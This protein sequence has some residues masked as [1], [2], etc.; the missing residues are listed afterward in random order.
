[1]DRSLP[2]RDEM[3][4]DRR[5]KYRTERNRRDYDVQRR[6]DGFPVPNYRRSFKTAE[7]DGYQNKRISRDSSSSDVKMGGR[8]DQRTPIKRRNPEQLIRAPKKARVIPRK[9]AT[10]DEGETNS[11]DDLKV[12]VRK[13]NEEL[14]DAKSEVD[15]KAQEIVNKDIEIMKLRKKAELKLKTVEKSNDLERRN[16]KL[17]KEIADL[18][19]DL[20]IEKLVVK[21]NDRNDDRKM[22]DDLKRIRKERDDLKNSLKKEKENATNLKE[23]IEDYKVTANNAMEKNLVMKKENREWA[24]KVNC[25][26][27]QLANLQIDALNGTKVGE[28]SD[29]QESDDENVNK[30]DD[31]NVNKMENQVKSLD[32]SNDETEEDV[33][34]KNSENDDAVEGED[35]EIKPDSNQTFIVEETLEPLENNESE[36]IILASDQEFEDE[37]FRVGNTEVMNYKNPKYAASNNVD[38]PSKYI[39]KEFKPVATT[40]NNSIIFTAVNKTK[41]KHNPSQGSGHCGLSPDCSIKWTENSNFGRVFIFDSINHPSNMTEKWACWHHIQAS[42]SGVKLQIQ[43]FVRKRTLEHEK[44]VEIARDA[45]KEDNDEKTKPNADETKPSYV[46][47]DPKPARNRL[48]RSRGR[49]DKLIDNEKTTATSY[50]KGEKSASGAGTSKK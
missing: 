9:E 29:N 4:P 36:D 18:K 45:K 13:L 25:L 40:L 7:R 16:K 17:L 15:V 6:S 10:D 28:T 24:L 8:N 34:P 20:E 5:M 44:K 49:K 14:K 12:K 39:N 19:S 30:S 23:K 31:E 2:R 43:K 22:S 48:T 38:A 33:C 26:E 21:H 11:V 50:K 27:N 47:G 42:V 35:H 41:L 3:S 1:M 32:I 37:N 46:D